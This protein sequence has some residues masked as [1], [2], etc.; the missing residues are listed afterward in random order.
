MTM[1]SEQQWKN[2]VAA[3]YP[4]YG[5]VFLCADG[6]LVYLEKRQI[7]ECALGIIVFVDGSFDCAWMHS[8]SDEKQLADIPRRFLQ[9]N[10]RQ[11]LSRRALASAEKIFGEQE[12]RKRG[13]YA[14]ILIPQLYWSSAKKLVARLRREFRDIEILEKERYQSQ[15]DAKLRE[16]RNLP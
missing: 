2:V 8:V 5:R 6:Y 3:L 14:P 1:P 7:S 10:R 4:P 12:C 15:L 13:W 11:R 16:P 9:I